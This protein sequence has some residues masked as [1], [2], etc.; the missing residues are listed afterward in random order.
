[1]P[2]LCIQVLNTYIFPLPPVPN[3]F[4]CLSVCLQSLGDI[5]L[6]CPN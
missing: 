1:M 5:V 3:S 4:K 2:I 6:D